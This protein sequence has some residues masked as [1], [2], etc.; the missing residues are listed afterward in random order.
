M[1]ASATALAL[2]SSVLPPLTAKPFWSCGE[3]KRG[4]GEEAQAQGVGGRAIGTGVHGQNWWR[5]APGLP[6]LASLKCLTP[7]A[8]GKAKGDG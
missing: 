8:P 3:R 6:F 2:L 5:R 7:F 1:S 4:Q